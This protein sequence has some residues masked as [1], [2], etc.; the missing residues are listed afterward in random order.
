M[1]H[2]LIDRSLHLILA[3]L[4]LIAASLLR[5]EFSLPPWMRRIL[6]LALCLSL[7]LK[8][9]IFHVAGLHAGWRHYFDPHYLGR[10]I[11][12][13]L[14]A[15]AILLPAAMG[16]F[17]REFPRSVWLI[18]CALTM[19]LT[20]GVR[21]SLL[22]MQAAVRAEPSGHS[23]RVLIHGLSDAALALLHETR[24]NAASDYQ[25]VGFLDE[26]PPPSRDSLMG[27]PVLGTHRQAAA[28]VDRMKK[29][30]KPIDE[31]II[32]LTSANG[33][34]LGEILANCR[35]SGVC[36]KTLPPLTEVLTAGPLTTRIRN[37]SVTDLLGR[38]P[39][40]LEKDRIQSSIAGRT[41]LVTGAAG[42]IGSE[43]CRQVMNYGPARLIA[44]DQAESDLYR[45]EC[46]MTGRSNGTQ[47][48]TRLGDIQDRA[49]LAEL[50]QDNCVDTIFHAAAYKHVPMLEHHVLEG[51]RNN[52]IGTWNLI[53]E[54]CCNRVS[55]FVMISSDKAVNPSSLMGATKRV[56]ELLVNAVQNSR[57]PNVPRCVSVRFGN[58]LGSNGSVVPLF[59][60]QIAAGGPVTVT[61]PE[62][63]RYFMTI[64]EAVMLVLQASTMGHG[65]EIFVLDM[66]QPMR[67]LDLAENMIYAAGLVPHQD[68]EIQFTGIRPGE[69][70]YEQL[71]LADERVLPTAHERV[72]IFA[73]AVQSW[74]RMEEWIRELQEDLDAR[75]TAGVLGHVMAL[76]PEYRADP[77]VVGRVLSRPRDLAVA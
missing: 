18:D 23:K 34:N 49:L 35:A 64:P 32:S 11:A 46:E 30:G 22:L 56:C 69:K 33:H 26:A 43:I 77:V 9:I 58:V 44:L 48:I 37:I 53:Q 66:G 57:L 17:G 59:Q 28:I 70:L 8:A 74:E 60:M 19:L 47:W 75:D 45:L 51:V 40:Q 31:I 39:V 61:H 65:S 14:A 2:H 5:F 25:V 42:S 71:G 73:D 10:L 41:I 72:R 55:N 24:S 63:R 12:A 1:K 36:C 7:A 15:C 62:M 6:P 4:S 20:G 3:A 67:I 68:V 76:V 16:I 13:N 27:A 38:K 29:A 54:A 52:V 50:L 21:F